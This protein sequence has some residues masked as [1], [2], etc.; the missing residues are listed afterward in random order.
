MGTCPTFL[1]K[2]IESFPEGFTA[3]YKTSVIAGPASVPGNHTFKIA[4]ANCDSSVRANG[5]P[6]NNTK[7]I[8]LFNAFNFFN[9]SF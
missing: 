2:V 9:K 5:L 4:S 6:V 7:T 8:G 3:P 1:G